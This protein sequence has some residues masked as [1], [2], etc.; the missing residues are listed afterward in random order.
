MAYQV[1]ARKYRP[2]RFAEVVGQEHVTRTLANA[3][4]RNRIAH[5]FLF[6]GPRGTGKTTI[7]RIFAKCLNCLDGPRLDFADDDARCQEISEGRS[8]DVLEIDGASNRGIEEIRELRQTVKYAP[9]VSRFKIYI[10]DEVHMLTK[11]AFN[12]LLK[13]LEE[14]PAHVKFMFA[15]TEPDKVPP[16][17]LSRCQ[18]FDLRRIPVRLIVQH[19]AQIAQW[20]KIEVDDAA[21]HAIARGADGCMRDAQ[22]ALDQ[23]ISFCGGR[24]AEED[25]LSMFGL[26][27]RPQI[28]A[29]AR[30]ILTG[31]FQTAMRLVDELARAGKE[32]G[33]VMAELVQHFHHLMLFQ[34]TGGDLGLLELTETEAAAVAEQAGLVSRESLTAILE[35][36]ADGEGRIRDAVSRRIAC[37]VVLLRAIEARHAIHW[38]TVLHQLKQ[39]RDESSPAS[40]PQPPD[41]PTHAPPRPAPADSH[42]AAARRAPAPPATPLAVSTTA[43]SAETARTPKSGH[44]LE[45]LWP[46]LIE[47]V[48]RSSRFTHSY[49][50]QAQ[51]V[52]FTNDLLVIGFA[53]EH[54]DTLGLVDTP[55]GRDLIQKALCQVLG[56]DAAVRVVPIQPAAASNASEAAKADSALPAPSDPPPAAVSPPPAPSA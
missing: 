30:S 37:E 44:S 39:W 13:T 8:L 22:S 56:R 5:A 12:A 7:A 50:M 45:T 20:E 48:K 43:P 47:S 25:V 3:I 21:L 33:R 27:G 54:S 32:I 28:L 19:L 15:T 26:A 42:T 53:P 4:E 38:D 16:T 2:Q 11:E 6:V 51:P 29:L 14:P 24:V 55:R 17:I 10:I 18:R 23:L 9:A 35:V 40:S 52:S 31:E 34:V 49:L 41:A 1:I 46:R 36:L